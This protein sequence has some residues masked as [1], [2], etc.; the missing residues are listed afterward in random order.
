[1]LISIALR[2]YYKIQFCHLTFINDFD[3]GSWVDLDNFE[4]SFSLIKWSI[5]DDKLFMIISFY[6]YDVL[7][8]L[9]L[10]WREL[11]L[12]KYDCFFL[13]IDILLLLF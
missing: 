5:W 10:D 4:S 11:N 12:N 6:W 2:T 9:T 3:Y 13:V 1:M 7:S 8:W